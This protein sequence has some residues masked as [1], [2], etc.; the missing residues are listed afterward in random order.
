MSNSL[1]E[2]TIL[3][4]GKYRNTTLQ[5]IYNKDQQYLKWLNTQ[6]WFKIKFTSIHNSLE[7]F[8]EENKEKIVINPDTI[9]IYTDGACKNNG[10]KSKYVSAGVGVHFSQDNYIQMN[11]ISKK[12]DIDSPTNNKAELIAILFALQECHKHNINKK[13]IIYT[14]SQ[15]C[16]DAITKW[17]DQWVK[18][19]NLKNKKNVSLIQSIKD[20]M[21][22]LDVSFI[23]IRGHTKKQDKHSIGN[24]RADNLATSCL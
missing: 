6:P 21:K 15:Y 18:S 24:E 22:M 9:I 11:D 20:I 7:K 14:D 1:N 23:H 10:S 2:S 17:Y 5:D 16:I 3:P 19:D 13:I 4:F 12:L 8:L